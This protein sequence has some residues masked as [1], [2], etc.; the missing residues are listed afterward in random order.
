MFFGFS[1]NMTIHMC[2]VYSQNNFF[3][4]VLGGNIFEVFEVEI[5]RKGFT[6][7]FV[8]FH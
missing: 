6:K 1:E 4:E 8:K 2:C 5:W 7:S 3:S